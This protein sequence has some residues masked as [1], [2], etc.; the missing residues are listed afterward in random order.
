MEVPAASERSDG[1]LNTVAF[2]ADHF[3]TNRAIWTLG[4]RSRD[5]IYGTSERGY[6]VR[7]VKCD[8]LMRFKFLVCRLNHLVFL[9]KVN[10]KLKAARVGMAR[11]MHRHFRMDDLQLTLVGALI[12]MLDNSLPRPCGEHGYES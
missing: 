6:R 11:A 3:D 9:R 5:P 12:C 1:R 4:I 2:P 10:P 8:E 7:V